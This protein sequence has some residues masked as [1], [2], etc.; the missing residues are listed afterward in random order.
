MIL[1]LPF[2]TI[3]KNA[4]EKV[5]RTVDE[6]TVEKIKGILIKDEHFKLSKRFQEFVVEHIGEDFFNYNE[7]RKIVGKE[8]F[9]VALVNAYN[10]IRCILH[11]AVCFEWYVK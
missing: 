9:R 5:F 3:K 7:K 4:L 2:G 10:I 8:E 6:E 1:I 11:I